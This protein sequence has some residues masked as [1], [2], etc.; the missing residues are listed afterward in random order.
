M[1]G[2]PSDINS[3]LDNSPHMLSQAL[4]YL[5]VSDHVFELNTAQSPN[6]GVGTTF[7]FDGGADTS[8]VFSSEPRIITPAAAQSQPTSTASQP[9]SDSSDGHA[10]DTSPKK[11]LCDSPGC[12]RRFRRPGELRKHKNN[13]IKPHKCRYCGSKYKGAAEKKDLIRHMLNHHADEVRDDP[14][15]P[16]KVFKCP[17]CKYKALR[18]DNVKRH[19]E[20]MGH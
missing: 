13:H 5:S 4:D 10:S 17:G 16:R 15:F 1:T 2:S 14:E 7:S 3:P 18:S 9:T 11:H 12:K 8:F 19:R 20:S 6:G